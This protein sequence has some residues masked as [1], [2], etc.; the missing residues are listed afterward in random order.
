MSFALSEEARQLIVDQ[1]LAKNNADFG[2]STHCNEAE[3]LK[4]KMFVLLADGYSDLKIVESVLPGKLEY[5]AQNSYWSIQEK[6]SALFSLTREPKLFLSEDF[7]IFTDA[8]NTYEFNFNTNTYINRFIE[9]IFREIDLD[10]NSSRSI[11]IQQT[12]VELVVNA[13]HDAPVNALKLV[14][15]EDMT[16]SLLVIEKNE[17]LLA[18]TV[19]DHYGTLNIGKFLTKIT[20]S[21]KIGRGQSINFGL[22]GAGLGGSLI[23]NHCDTLMLGCKPN[24]KTRVTSV[25]PYNLNED[26]LSYIQKSIFLF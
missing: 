8:T 20:S 6:M 11:P 23:Y 7:N 13:Q 15:P 22:G 14:R 25:L 18:I 3:A 4:Q 2:C 9:D 10:I 26:K 19:I 21:L 24:K 12:I 1:F 5:V 17:K 16:D